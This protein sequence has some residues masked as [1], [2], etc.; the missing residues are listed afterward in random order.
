VSQSF[1]FASP[2]SSKSTS[3]GRILSIH[4]LTVAAAYAGQSFVYRTGESSYENDPYAEFVVP[5][6]EGLRQPLEAHLRASGF[7]RD[8]VEPDSALQPDT[9]VEI[10]VVRLYGDFRQRTNPVA[11]LEMRFVFFD[12]QSRT[13]G[14]VILDKDYSEKIR[15]KNRTAAALMAGWN[16][17][18]SQI[19]KRL[20][21]DLKA[22]QTRV[23]V[24][25]S[26]GTR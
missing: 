23:P 25:G 3:Q 15:L 18:L 14:K 5:P 13:T 11:E 20:A 1:N 12:A 6:E 8:V 2:S 7:F 16:T 17:G 9:L 21:E 24:S 4:R 22:H 19:M 26:S 10:S